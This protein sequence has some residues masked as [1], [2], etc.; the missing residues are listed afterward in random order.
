M[1]RRARAEGLPITAEATADTSRSPTTFVKYDT[2]YKMNPPLRNEQDRQA[3][4]QGLEDGTIDAIATDHAPHAL[5]EKDQDIEVAPSVRS[6]WS[7]FRSRDD[8]TFPRQKNGS[9]KRS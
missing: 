4:I 3:V 1:I 7:R 9:S 6:D 2:F 5:E 8:G